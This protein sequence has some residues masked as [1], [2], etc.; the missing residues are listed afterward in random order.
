[1]KQIIDIFMLAGEE[2]SYLSSSTKT[3]LMILLLM[4]FILAILQTYESYKDLREMFK[5][6]R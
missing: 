3:I 5:A 6:D 2:I 4:A 1:M